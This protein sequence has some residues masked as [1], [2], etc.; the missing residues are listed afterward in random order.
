MPGARKEIP[1]GRTYNCYGDSERQIEIGALGWHGTFRALLRN[2]V[3]KYEVCINARFVYTIKHK[4]LEA[5]HSKTDAY[6]DGRGWPGA[7][8]R[9]I[10]P[11]EIIREKDSATIAQLRSLGICYQ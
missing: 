6:I 1:N 8:I 5:G 3:P 9:A 10:C 7:R 2:D 4:P 11:Q